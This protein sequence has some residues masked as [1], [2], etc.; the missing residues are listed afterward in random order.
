M[1]EDVVMADENQELKSGDGAPL[2]APA[3][4][5]CGGDAQGGRCEE[6]DIIADEYRELNSVDGGEEPL[7]DE[8]VDE[9]RTRWLPHDA[10][11]KCDNCRRR[12][13]TDDVNSP[14]YFDM[15]MIYSHKIKATS[16]PLRKIKAHKTRA[17]ALRNYSR[18]RG[19]RNRYHLCRECCGFLSKEEAEAA[20]TKEEKNR[21]NRSRFDWGKLWPSF[22][23]DLL[24]GIDTDSGVPFRHV[25]EASYL[26]R[27]IPQSI[28]RYWLHEEIFDK[29]GDFF[30][31]TEFNPPSYFRD[32]TDELQDFALKIKS[33]TARD[34]LNALDPARL[35]GD[36]NDENMNQFLLPDVLC[37]WG[38]GEYCHAAVPMNSS[39]L[40][41]RHL[42]KV[43]LNLSGFFGH[44]KLY[45]YENSRLDYIRFDKE[46]IDTVL[47]NDDWKVLP[48]VLLVPGKGLCALCCRHHAS[49]SSQRRLYTHP[50]KKIENILSST[51]PDCLSHCVLKPRVA[52]TV[53]GKKYNT[54]M[55]ANYLTC[56][57]AGCDSANVCLNGKFNIP[58]L[59][60]FKHEVLSFCGRRDL[61]DLASAKVREGKITSELREQWEDEAVKKYGAKQD[62]L[63]L[64]SRGSTYVP[65]INALLLQKHSTEESR[66]DAVVKIRQSAGDQESEVDASLERS[67]TPV[68]YNVQTQDPEGYGAIMKGIKPYMA[69]AGRATMMLWTLVGMVS[70]CNDLHYAIDQ[71]RGGHRY[72]YHSGHLLA[73]INAHYMKHRDSKCPRKSPFNGRNSAAS[74]LTKVEKSLPQDMRS[75]TESDESFYRFDLEY[76]K[77]LFVETEYP[78][79]SVCSDISEVV[80]EDGRY[81]DEKQ[82]FITVGKRGPEGEASFKLGPQTFEARVVISL[83]IEDG[84]RDSL[85]PNHY[86]GRRFARHGGGFNEWWEQKRSRR[87]KTKQMMKQYVQAQSSLMVKDP[88][89]VLPPSSFYYVCVY[90][91]NVQ[92]QANDFRLDMF[93]SVGAQCAVFCSCMKINPLILCGRK[94]ANRRRCMRD[95]CESHEK[96]SCSNFGCNTRVCDECFKNMANSGEDVVL[97]P[98]VG[99]QN[100]EFIDFRDGN[101]LNEDNN[102]IGIDGEEGDWEELNRHDDVNDDDYLDSDE[103]SDVIEGIDENDDDEFCLDDGWME[104]DADEPDEH[105]D[106]DPL[107]G[108]ESHHDR[109]SLD[110]ESDDCVGMDVNV[111]EAG[112]SDAYEDYVSTFVT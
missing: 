96:Y 46:G 3:S 68:I 110:G 51:R 31:C 39:L 58:S 81:T 11:R 1:R 70:A 56:G 67:W 74:L 55:Q 34:F 48:S 35:G 24:V 42:T 20:A 32:R 92:P 57:Y 75:S 5:A 23:W 37:P 105:V 13:F 52:S 53:Q 94:K 71:K 26:W 85:T 64:A 14:Y 102:V 38:C 36:P 95:G 63:S 9:C 40:I 30:G 54:S 29:D 73:H 6:E 50:P 98:P 77:N 12:C 86:I 8:G 47:M 16:S 62:M 72:D 41:Q 112:S 27:Y 106:I 28:R 109:E 88:F 79:V 10:D 25:Y 108:E 45:L 33:Y 18:G 91:K 111:G 100:D 83:E 49:S 76:M 99:E 17:T 65:T 15:C 60:L 93:R 78:T 97:D 87:K 19:D 101:G 43:Q 44:D 104:D 103:Y 69:K 7:L 59:M 107:A 21:L 82:V 2:S 61:R 89:P 84:E 80:R 66:I 22:Y 4:S 90:V